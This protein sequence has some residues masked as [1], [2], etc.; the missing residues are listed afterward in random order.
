MGAPSGTIGQRREPAPGG[1]DIGERVAELAWA[2]ARRQK[3]PAAPLSW[4]IAPRTGGFASPPFDGC[5]LVSNRAC[6]LDANI[7]CPIGAAGIAAS[8][9]P[10]SDDL[11]A[12]LQREWEYGDLFDANKCDYV[13][14]CGRPTVKIRMRIICAHRMQELQPK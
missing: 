13:A 4:E 8:R 6:A 2:L 9:D 1:C 11:E 14:V 12:V 7:Q 5:A 3:L 10:W